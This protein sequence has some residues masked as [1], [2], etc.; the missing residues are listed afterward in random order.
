MNKQ[1]SKMHPSAG[2][3]FH[4]SMCHHIFVSS[5]KLPVC[6]AINKKDENFVNTSEYIYF[7]AITSKSEIKV[8]SYRIKDTTSLHMFRSHDTSLCV[9]IVIIGAMV[10]MLSA[11]TSIRQ[12]VVVAAFSSNESARYTTRSFESLQMEVQSPPKGFHSTLRNAYGSKSDS[13]WRYRSESS[14]WMSTSSATPTSADSAIIPRVKTVDAK[15]ASDG[16]P[17]LIKGWVRTV[18]KQ[19]TLA[20]VEVND[21]SNM[22]GIQCVLSFDSI[23]EQTQKGTVRL[24]FVIKLA[25]GDVI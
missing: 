11:S 23:D 13:S 4:P 1:I 17:V 8:K 15:E 12:R 2:S 3:S 10:L 5:E 14:L 6:L 24:F 9:R 19:K 7:I 20:F 21:G 18:R 25:R 22:N 16:N